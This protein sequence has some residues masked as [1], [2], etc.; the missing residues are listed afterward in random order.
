MAAHST[1]TWSHRLLSFAS[2]WTGDLEGRRDFGRMFLRVCPYF[3]FNSRICIN[4]HEWLACRLRAEGIRHMTHRGVLLLTPGELDRFSSVG[5]FNG[6]DELYLAAEWNDEFEV[7]PGRIS[8]DHV[9]FEEMT[10]LGLEE[11]MV[12]AGCFLALGEGQGLNFATLDSQLAENLR[13]RFPT[14]KARR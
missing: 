3:P 12:D 5:L 1:E 6:Q 2:R 14:T 7:F 9:D 13:A 4:G 11:W 8:T 10:P